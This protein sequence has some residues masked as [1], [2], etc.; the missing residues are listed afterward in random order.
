MDKLVSELQELIERAKDI[1]KT[2]KDFSKFCLEKEEAIL[3]QSTDPIP[4]PTKRKEE[5]R[6]PKAATISETVAQPSESAVA[7]PLEKIQ[8][9]PDV[10]KV[11]IIA[12]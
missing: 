10:P 3:S 1:L 5:F 9:E 11:H 6:S 12:Y 8:D 2:N 4:A 7:K